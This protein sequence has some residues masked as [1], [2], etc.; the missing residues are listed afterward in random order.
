MDFNRETQEVFISIQQAARWMD[1]FVKL[2]TMGGILLLQYFVRMA[3]EKKLREGTVKDFSEFVKLTEGKYDIMNIPAM[4]TEQI[5]KELKDLGVRHMLLP[6]LNKEDGMLQV[7]VYQ[8]DKD[9]FGAWYQR[10]ILSEMKGGKKDIQ[11]LR[12]LTNGRT[13]ILSLPLESLPVQW[14]EDFKEMQINYATLP[15]LRVGDGQIQVIVANSD[16]PQVEHWYKLMKDDLAKEGTILEDYDT[17]SMTE[18]SQTGKMTEQ[19]YINGA[20][21]GYKEANEKYEG[22]E[23]GKVET[24]VQENQPLK[25]ETAASFE[26]YVNDPAYLPL[27]VDHDTL[28]EK[29]SCQLRDF[30]E[31]GQFACRIPGTWGGNDGELLLVL[32]LS[33][34]FARRDGESYLAFIKKDEPPQVIGAET[35]EKAWST[36]SGREFARRYFDRVGDDALHLDHARG[37]SRDKA[38]NR[39]GMEL[40][41]MDIRQRQGDSK[42]ASGAPDVSLKYKPDPAPKRPERV[43]PSPVLKR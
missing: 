25:N 30:W 14:E 42:K 5:T 31:K 26:D 18:Y 28:I 10:H 37:R 34:V 8:M 20:E 15:D 21:E 1:P 36:L 16:L 24:A 11:D 2:T 39:Q 32:P 43:I 17:I 33:Q 7:A 3:T 29:S 35:G 9:K 22:Q 41:R 38:V 27:S 40:E 23:K 13:S 19:S 6:D 4:D 12:N